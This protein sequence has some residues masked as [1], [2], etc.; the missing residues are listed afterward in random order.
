MRR[1]LTLAL[2][3]A[4]LAA[5]C[6]VGEDDDEPDLSPLTSAELGWIRAYSAW[7]I[8]IYDDERHGGPRV[9]AECEEEEA[10]LGPTPTDRLEPAAELATGICPLLAEDGTWRRALDT[11]DATD[12]LLRTLLR[13]EQPL[14]LAAGV[15]EGSRADTELSAYATDVVERPVEVRCW[16]TGDWRRVVV[17][18]NAWT[19]SSDDPETLYGWADDTSDRI[20]MRLDQCN[21]LARL[22]EQ[23]TSDKSLA[24]RREAADSLGTLAHEI[25]HFVLPDASESKV[26]C[27]GMRSLA[28]VAQRLGLD[29]ESALAL[30]DLYRAEIYP[31]QPDEYIE[32][33][34]PQ[35]P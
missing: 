9:V 27:A 31:E 29:R 15:T 32:G 1:L 12:N 2:V 34:C 23:A 28:A 6:S 24:A 5:G 21:P 14:E 35:R 4:L 11:V 8:G 10:G 26:E 22:D 16:S 17:E 3:L 25:Q 33:G 13:D 18:D 20:Q 30:A 19:D 7:T